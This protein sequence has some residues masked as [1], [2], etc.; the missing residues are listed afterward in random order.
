MW[1]GTSWSQVCAVCAPGT[2]GFVSM[3]TTPGGVLLYGGGATFGSGAV[4]PDAWVFADGT[5][6]QLCVTCPPGP[7]AGAAMAGGGVNGDQV[8]L[9]GG[10]S[11]FSG[12]PGTVFNDTWGLSGGTWTLLDAGIAGD[13][14]PRVGA[15]MA[16]DG[17]QFILFGGSPID[18]GGGV[19]TPIDDGTWAWA[20]DHWVQLCADAAA[21]GPAPRSLAYLAS[22][23]ST[24]PSRRGV[25][26]VGGLIIS[27]SPVVFGDIWLWHDGQWIQQASPWADQQPAEAP[28]GP[29]FFVAGLASR[30]ASCQVSLVGSVG[31]RTPSTFNLG[32]DTNGDGVIDP[33]PVVQPPPPT[34]ENV[35]VPAA[36]TPGAAA[37]ATATGTLP[38]TGSDLA[39][40]MSF[41]TALL[42]VGLILVAS[43]RRISSRRARPR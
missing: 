11:D 39:G 3:A 24:D 4:L 14:A 28:T 6:T 12:D 36:A 29:L 26:L 17:T 41:A 37:E 19:G 2:R 43:S 18:S 42:G 38:F 7:R 27:G 1:N 8:L 21:C 5:W 22:L 13:P 40:P 15:S 35:V 20:G 34:P 10:A 31:T 33:C 32:L 9:F 16:W 30:T 23:A 25:L